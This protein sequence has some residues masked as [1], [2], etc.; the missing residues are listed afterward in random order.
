MK[1]KELIQQE[2]NLQVENIQA[3]EALQR[4]KDAQIQISN[5]LKPYPNNSDEYIDTQP[6]TQELF[7]IR[8]SN[9]N[10]IRILMQRNKKVMLVVQ[11]Y[12][13]MINEAYDYIASINANN[14]RIGVPQSIQSEILSYVKEDNFV[15]LGALLKRY[16]GVE[17]ISDHYAYALR[18]AAC[19]SMHCL[20]F[21]IN[22]GYANIMAPGKSGK[23]AL[24]YAIEQNKPECV[25]A[26]LNAK[27]PHGYYCPAN[28]LLFGEEPERPIDYLRRFDR[29]A[30]IEII[31]DVME[32][33]LG[34]SEKT[35]EEQREEIQLIL[36]GLELQDHS[37]ILV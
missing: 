28:Q 2:N 18:I 24:H 3:K 7:R 25:K 22:T 29:T 4:L 23:I 17:N 31:R 33:P 37:C 34:Q 14:K 26:L 6:L 11:S 19:G 12:H 1:K 13:R 36:M 16:K 21:L 27:D 9:G 32:G 35:L 30:M 5:L 8:L 15:K 20:A 10:C